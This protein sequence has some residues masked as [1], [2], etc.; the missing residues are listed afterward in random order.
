MDTSV[1]E[2]NFYDSNQDDDSQSSSGSSLQTWISWFC[3]LS[4]HEYYVEVPEDYIDDEFNLQGLS[5]IVPYYTQALETILDLECD[6]LF[7]ENEEEDEADVEG[8]REEE[9]QQSHNHNNQPISTTAIA[10]TSNKHHQEEDDFWKEE[11]KTPK[12]LKSKDPRV[13]EPYAF[14]LY[15]LIHQRYLLSREGLRVMAERYSNCQFGTCPRYLCYDSP[16]LPVGRYDETGRE[17]VY[18]Y[19]PRCL[20]IYNPPS[21]IYRCVDG[22]HFGS[23]YCHLLFLTYPELVPDPN[24]VI[25]EPRIF[26]FRVS[27]KSLTGP[28]N[29]W[30]RLRLIKFEGNNPDET[31]DVE[32]DEKVDA[33]ELDEEVLALW[34]EEQHSIAH[35]NILPELVQQTENLRI[36]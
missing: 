35:N 3:S 8:E 22:A 25:Y 12:R 18:L 23:T 26:G 19:C 21:S 15:G 16:V 7:G 11:D 36:S 6:E 34:N 4:G 1:E 2:D 33:N 27:P 28:R 32:Q 31:D 20:D 24:P 14:M 17:S 29:Q 13:I 10:T 9:R 30:L 5:T